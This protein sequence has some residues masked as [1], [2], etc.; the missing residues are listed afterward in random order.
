MLDL[1]QRCSRKGRCSLDKNTETSAIVVL[2]AARTGVFETR[3]AK[4]HFPFNFINYDFSWYL[5][6]GA[7]NIA[8][9]ILTVANVESGLVRDCQSPS[10]QNISDISMEKGSRVGRLFLSASV[11]F[12]GLY[13]EIS[14]NMLSLDGL[15]ATLPSCKV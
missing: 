5:G 15:V 8:N 4:Q 11:I 14:R 2:V 1:Q 9:W 12:A 13:G 7:C 6:C 10:K 3:D